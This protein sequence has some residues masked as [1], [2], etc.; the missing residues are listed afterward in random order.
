LEL[1][2]GDKNYDS[3]EV[4]SSFLE[5]LKKVDSIK[6]K[7]VGTHTCHPYKDA[8]VF[9][10]G[11]GTLY[12]L[13]LTNCVVDKIWL[14]YIDTPFEC[15]TFFPYTHLTKFT[16][17]ESRRSGGDSWVEYEFKN[18][19]EQ[20]YLT[21]MKS[22]VEVGE[23]RENRT[24]TPTYSV[25]C[26]QR[27]EFDLSDNQF[28]LLTTKRCVLRQIFVELQFYLSGRS[29]SKELEKEKVFVWK[30]N[31]SREFLDNRGLSHYK[32]GDMGPSYSF[33]FR[34]LGADY[35]GC[36]KSYVG[37]G[38][39]QL[40]YCIDLIRNDPTSRRII[41]DL[42]DPP[43]MDQM[44]LPPCMFLYQFYVSNDKCLYCHATLRSSDTLLGL[45]W[46][47]ATASLLTILM[48]NM[49]DLEPGSVTITAND[50]HVYA[51]QLDGIQT[52]LS[53]TPTTFPKLF[54]ETDEKDITKVKWSD[55]CLL[56]YKP[57]PGIKVPMVV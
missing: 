55:L 1:P 16:R 2:K 49:C 57:Y 23:F 53:R 7:G 10:I 22:I 18:I 29:D 38:F 12:D 42:W 36:D 31:T 40:Q 56:N 20:Q 46:N 34:H 11:G 43:K 24:E 4:V 15:D 50:A 25:F 14:T 44:S 52:Q 45:P 21:Y 48:A 35:K 19:E 33:N 39:D 3:T 9:V 54:V 28:P 8:S 32:E 51:N 37:K 41:I 47:I 13:F 27:L 6:K 26:P 30:G 17:K 5:I